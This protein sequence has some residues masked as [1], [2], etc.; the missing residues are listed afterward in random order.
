MHLNKINT[1]RIDLLTKITSRI[2]LA[3]HAFKL[4]LRFNLH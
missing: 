3:M 2:H 1:I 4:D